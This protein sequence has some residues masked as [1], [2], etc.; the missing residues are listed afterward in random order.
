[1]ILP[2]QAGHPSTIVDYTATQSQVRTGTAAGLDRMYVLEWVA[3]SEITEH[4]TIEDYVAVLDEVVQEVGGP[5]NLVGDCQ[6]G[7]LATIYAALRP[8]NVA[9]LSIG[10]APIDFHAGHGAIVDWMTAFRKSVDDPMV[11]YRSLVK[12]GRGVHRGQNQLDGFKLMEPAGELTRLAELWANIGD[13][14]YVERYTDFVSW[15]ETT[16]DMPGDFYLWTVEH[17]FVDNEVVAGTLQVGGETVDLGKITAP[18]YLLAGTRDHITP[19]EQVWALADHA[20][21]P[22]EDVHA[23]LFEAG[24]LG[25]FMGRSSLQ[26][27]WGPVFGDIA[28]STAARAAEAKSAEAPETL[29]EE[30][31]APEVPAAPATTAKS[32]ATTS[33][34]A[35]AAPAKTTRTRTARTTGATA[36]KTTAA[37]TGT[38]R[39]SASKTST[40][41]SSTTRKPAAKKTETDST[42]AAANKPAQKAPAK[43][44]ETEGK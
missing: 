25:L 11:V 5:V 30:K 35:E 36:K 39:A 42:A 19:P 1:M 9:T 27:H 28:E 20:S 2:P 10:A 13:E 8:E 38:A 29:F 14:A 18:L 23:R 3:A 41:K 22:R 4:T 16:Q 17:L 34:S 21:T 24:H 40:A 31:A 33:T 32:A 6:G 37:K 44:A 26:E 7:W 43:P 15:F 12:A